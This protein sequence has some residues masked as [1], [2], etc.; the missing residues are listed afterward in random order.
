MAKQSK[1]PVID[2]YLREVA[3]NSMNITDSIKLT[4]E[5]LGVA[6]STVSR[7]RAADCVPGGHDIIAILS[8]VNKNR[9]ADKKCTLKDVAI[10]CNYKDI[11][12]R[13]IALEKK[14]RDE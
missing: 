11:H 5:A 2:R 8:E 13:L 10:L 4:A 3:P 9:P 14:D 6:P 12:K 7:W 1:S